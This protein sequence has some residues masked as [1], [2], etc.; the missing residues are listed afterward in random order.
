MGIRA[1]EP[2]FGTEELLLSLVLSTNQT[3]AQEWLGGASALPSSVG[4]VA[5]AY[6][7]ALNDSFAPVF[8]VDS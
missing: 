1:D 8:V 5:F 3:A 2:I 6:F 7:S 4:S